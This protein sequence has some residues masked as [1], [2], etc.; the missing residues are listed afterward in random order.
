MAARH[1]A[2]GLKRALS[3]AWSSGPALDRGACREIWLSRLLFFYF[4]NFFFLFEHRAC[5]PPHSILKRLCARTISA[6]GAHH[7]VNGV[8]HTRSRYPSCLCG[9]H[10]GSLWLGLRWWA[11]SCTHAYEYSR[12]GASSTCMYVGRCDAAV[13]RHSMS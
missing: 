8:G 4:F 12:Q 5:N 9:S 13:G 7:C 10:N 2:V 6:I 11:V 1:H 3:R